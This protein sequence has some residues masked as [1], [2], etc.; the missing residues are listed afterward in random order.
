MEQRSEVLGVKVVG[1]VHSLGGRHQGKWDGSR[2]GIKEQSQR[3]LS[4][5]DVLCYDIVYC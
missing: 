4:F 2:A 1:G 3:Q 5:K